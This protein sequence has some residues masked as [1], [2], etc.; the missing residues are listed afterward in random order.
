MRN[1]KFSKNILDKLQTIRRLLLN[2][3][4]VVRKRIEPF[5]TD[6]TVKFLQLC[7]WKSIYQR[8]KFYPPVINLLNHRKEKLKKKSRIG[9]ILEGLNHRN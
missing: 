6:Y 1:H 8:Q 7:L 4:Q 2:M 9:F 5:L 3:N